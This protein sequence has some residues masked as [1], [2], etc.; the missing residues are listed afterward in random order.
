MCFHCNC[1]EDSKDTCTVKWI[2]QVMDIEYHKSLGSTKSV[3]SQRRSVMSTLQG[4]KRRVK[5]GEKFTYEFK[6]V[7]S[8]CKYV[9]EIQNILVTCSLLR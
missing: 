5:S 9:F 6:L 8:A 3:Y 2:H 7:I 4:N 1:R